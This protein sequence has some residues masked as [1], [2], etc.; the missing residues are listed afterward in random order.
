MH[1][2]YK[3][4]FNSANFHAFPLYAN[5]L[6]VDVDQELDVDMLLLSLGGASL[7]ILQTS[8]KK[9]SFVNTFLLA[10]FSN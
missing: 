5:V 1:C 6:P 7:P 2:K 8:D 3:F 4:N 9:Y 10:V